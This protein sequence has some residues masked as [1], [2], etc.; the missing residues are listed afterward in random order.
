VVVWE[1]AMTDAKLRLRKAVD[2][3]AHDFGDGEHCSDLIAKIYEA[4]DAIPEPRSGISI[5]VVRAW[6]V[7]LRNIHALLSR[8][9]E[10]SCAQEEGER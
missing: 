4:I 5:E 2:D 1:K 6:A 3:L 9:M 10:V 7:R 8:E